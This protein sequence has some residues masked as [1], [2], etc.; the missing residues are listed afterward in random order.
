MSRIG[1]RFRPSWL[2]WLL[3]VTFPLSSLAGET[4]QDAGDAPK[5]LLANTYQAGVD[6]S[7]YWV[8]EKLD[9]VRAYWDGE[10]LT[11]RGGRPIRPPAWFTEG[12]PPQP[13]DG[14]LWMG[15]G[16]FERMSAAA[17]QETPDPAVWRQV[18]FMVFDLPASPAPFGER[19]N[20]LR[21][22]LLPAPSPYLT[23]IDQF[24][25]SGHDALMVHLDIVFREGGEGL[26]LHREDSL[27][28]AGRSA[29]LLKVKP[30]L[31]AEARVIAHLPGK[32][33]LEGLLGALLVEE[34][35][36]GTRFRLG[37]G[38]TDAQRRAPPPIGSLV[39]FKYQGRTARGLPRF[40]SFLRR[41][42][43]D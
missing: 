12:F 38:F 43:P 17:R 19:L 15:R 34:E 29:D 27:Y 18:R 39:T 26:M 4:P 14:E 16:T 30:Y 9:G 20:A 21:Q 3:L 2:F 41:K 37:S 33:R 23:L 25:V 7:R 1:W 8:S 36:T 6:L 24:R 22:L 28:R 35:G 40:P 11:S 31:D 32:G 13:L 42:Q 5:L 10:R